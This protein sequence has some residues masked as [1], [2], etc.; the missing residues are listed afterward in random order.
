M[1]GHGAA[2]AFLATC[3]AAYPHGAFACARAVGPAAFFPGSDIYPD[4]IV[5]EGIVLIGDAA[6]ANDP[7]QGQGISL[8]FRDVRELRDLLVTQEWQAAIEEFARRRPSWYEPL[9]AYAIWDGP[10]FTDVGPDADA[11]RA[12]QRRAAERDPW[13][14]G[15]GVINALG[16]E[17]LPVTEAARRQYLGDDLD[18]A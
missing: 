1:R 14:N 6:G 12:R 5:G 8:A 9:R 10:L 11:A 3:A 13:R 17:G 16:P 7:S 2:E 18:A 4:R 15:Y